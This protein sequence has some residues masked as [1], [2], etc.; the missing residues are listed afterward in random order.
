M[1]LNDKEHYDLLK[2]FEKTF[3]HL[4]LDREKDIKYQK[5]GIMYESGVT[6]KLFKAY[7]WGYSFGLTVGREDT[8]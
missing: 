7:R 5:M 4:R 1:K 8:L 3:P 6:N 2:Q